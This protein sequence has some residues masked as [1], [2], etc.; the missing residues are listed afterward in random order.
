MITWK[1]D[2]QGKLK[3]GNRYRVGEESGEAWENVFTV[4]SRAL[5][6]LTP[7]MLRPGF[8][9]GSRNRESRMIGRATPPELKVRIVC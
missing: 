4:Y 9:P 8:E 5:W 6:M 3:K 1:R 7:K 2:Y